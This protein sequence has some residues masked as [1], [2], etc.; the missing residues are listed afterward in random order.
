M[1][2]VATVIASLL[3]LINFL[4]NPFTDGVGG[5]KPVAMERALDVI[6]QATAAADVEVEV[7]CDDEGRPS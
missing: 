7:P 3:L 1:G 5:V 6:D 4:D 2:S